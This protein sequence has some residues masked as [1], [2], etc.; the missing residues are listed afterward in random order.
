MHGHEEIKKKYISSNSANSLLSMKDYRKPAVSREKYPQPHLGAKTNPRITPT[1]STPSQP[2]SAASEI[3]SPNTNNPPKPAP[4]TPAMITLCMAIPNRSTQ[5][6][7]FFHTIT[8]TAFPSMSTSRT[9]S[10]RRM[11]RTSKWPLW[12]KKK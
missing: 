1:N 10:P 5:S 6:S 8:T 11:C 7:P 12:T 2:V 4:S 3:T 9:S